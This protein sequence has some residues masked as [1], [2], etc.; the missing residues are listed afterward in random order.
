MV[1]FAIETFPLQG[2]DPGP[3]QENGKPGIPEC[4]GRAGNP[5]QGDSTPETGKTG[6]GK[7]TQCRGCLS[8]QHRPRTFI[9]VTGI[10]LDNIVSVFVFVLK[11][12]REPN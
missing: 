2:G 6:S 12:C 5:P 8:I 10:V 4:R 1:F 9:T 3:L 7:S 11:E